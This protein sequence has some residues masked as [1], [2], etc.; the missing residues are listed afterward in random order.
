MELLKKIDYQEH[1]SKFLIL[2]SF[3]ITLFIVY[4]FILIPVQN[5][6][7]KRGKFESLEVK[8]KKEKKLNDVS[9]MKYSKLLEE[10]EK[11]KKYYSDLEDVSKKKSFENISSFESFISEKANSYG[12]TIETIGRVEKIEETDKVYLP[13]IISGDISKIFLFIE[14]LENSD[15]KISITDSTTIISIL[16]QERITTKLSANVLI[17][18]KNEEE[19]SELLPISKLNNIAINKIK[20]LNFNN[21]VY[22]ILNYK[23]GNKSI[24][25]AGEEIL[26]DNMK[27]EVI[28]KNGSPFLKL[29]KN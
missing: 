19:Y 27:Y 13:Y 15:R 23:N 24:F 14:E 21:K 7:N 2:L 29:I 18:K 16:P 5:Y 8:N 6:N 11:T 4:H 20:Y 10:L 25:Y 12:L 28:L 17:S 3:A 26:F 1:K 22:I 9:S